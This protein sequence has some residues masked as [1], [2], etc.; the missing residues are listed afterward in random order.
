MAAPNLSVS[1][2]YTGSAAPF[3]AVYTLAFLLG[4]GGTL[5]ALWGFTC[6]RG[7]RRSMDVYL[8]NL[9]VSDVLLTLA[10]PFR[11]ATGLDAAPWGLRVFHC[12]ASA[13]LVYINLYAS[14]VFLALVSVDRY[15][16]IA[17]SPRLR[18][19]REAGLAR[20][21]SALTWALVLF[22]MVPN[23]AIPVRTLPERRVLRCADLKQEAGLRWHKLATFI[24]TAVFLNASVAVLAA[25]GLALRRLWASRRL[26]DYG[27]GGRADGRPVARRT[28]RHIAVVTLAY[29]VCFVPYHAVRPPYTLSQG[30]PVANCRQ[31]SLYLAKECTLLLAVL[32]LCVNPFLY[33]HFSRSFRLRLTEAFRPKGKVSTPAQDLEPSPQ[34]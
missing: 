23:M 7:P 15:L 14:I 20:V 9:L 34:P 3:T 11:I 1:C 25:N 17:R 22:L 31:W 33:F 5:T 16:Q 26:G 30:R 27:G 21:M 32:H 24:A 28:A 12:Q 8:L 10:L 4:L 29:V 19:A 18:W 13:V 2:G 6:G